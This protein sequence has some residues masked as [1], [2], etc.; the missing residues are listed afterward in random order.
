MHMRQ[1][2]VAV[3]ALAEAAGKNGNYSSS[4]ILIKP[5]IKLRCK[6]ASTRG[7]SS[8][9]GELS[10]VQTFRFG[11]GKLKGSGNSGPFRFYSDHGSSLT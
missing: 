5:I 9:N 7:A 1:D 4:G 10:Q 2:T 6:M 8:C 11:G 3:Y